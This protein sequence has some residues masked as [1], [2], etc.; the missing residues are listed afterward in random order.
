VSTAAA[1]ERTRHAYRSVP[2]F[3]RTNGDLAAELGV[4]LGLVPDDDQRDILDAI[5]AETDEGLPACFEVAAVAPRQNIKTS[6]LELAALTDLYVM[7]EP[8]H[9]WTAHKFDTAQKAYLDMRRL[10]S[11]NP[12]YRSRTKFTDAR[13]DEAIEF[14]DTGGRIEFHARSSGA[15]RGATAAKTTLDEAMFLLPVHV[16]ALLPTMATI[17]GAQVRYGSSAGMVVSGVLRGVRARGRTGAD[18]TLGYFEWCAPRKD[19]ATPTCVHL[20][21]VEG[22]ALDDRELWRTANP[23][24]GRRI[25]EESLAR[26][27]RAMPPEEFMREFL[28]WWEDPDAEGGAAIPA[29]W[30]VA[31]Q[32]RSS[33]FGD[34]PSSLGVHISAD[35]STAYVVA[36]GARPDG[37]CHVEVVAECP[38]SR[39][40]RALV[41]L[42]EKR[43]SPVVLDAGSHAGSLVT[44][45]ETAGLPVVQIK[46]GELSAAAGSLFDAV[47]DRTLRHIGQ[48]QLDL[49]VFG[50]TTRTTT[51]D[52]WSW[53]GPATAPLVAATLAMH[54]YLSAATESEG[55]VF[56]E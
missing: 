26:F 34:G 9:L 11:S 43:P 56:F 30:W 46:L 25:S 20:V 17:P 13:G 16:G 52:A 21:G 19:C 38:P 27:R 48:A 24:F 37:M 28:G 55:W 2:A 29:E 3:A 31:C 10:I 15:G 32:D 7:G 53:K 6:T 45:L 33:R 12:D 4:H 39:A 51:R 23:A 54:G 36:V 44:D 49:A 14:V 41:A 40:V 35:R 1:P 18:P 47:K 5:F 8:L 22:C 50:A 42:H